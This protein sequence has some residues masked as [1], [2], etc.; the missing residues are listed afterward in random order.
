MNGQFFPWSHAYI[1]SIEYDVENSSGTSVC[2]RGLK[3]KA[4]LLYSN[5]VFASL[6][7]SSAPFEARQADW[8]HLTPQLLRSQRFPPCAPN[9]RTC[10][11]CTFHDTTI[12]LIIPPFS[13][14]AGLALWLPRLPPAL[15]TMVKILHERDFFLTVAAILLPFVLTLTATTVVFRD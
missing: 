1:I 8:P 7:F 12:R 3:A 15:A 2:F 14:G 10:R 13:Q 11:Q 9:L 6:S 4:E 5:I